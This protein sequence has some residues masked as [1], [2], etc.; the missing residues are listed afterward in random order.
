MDMDFREFDGEL[1]PDKLDEMET[2]QLA[3]RL[4]SNYIK[5][6][7]IW[8]KILWA[9][10]TRYFLVILCVATYIV[11]LRFQPTRMILIGLYIFF[12]IFWSF[13]PYAFK[14]VLI[15]KITS[16]S[17]CVHT[18]IYAVIGLIC[19]I[20]ALGMYNTAE[21]ERA[22]ALSKQKFEEVR[23]MQRSKSKKK[24]DVTADDLDDMFRP[25]DDDE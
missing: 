9:I 16:I 11:M 6:L 13:F 23:Q 12:A 18:I 15:Y 4:F 10:I 22:K 25:K 19:W 5:D 24:K 1:T 20:I 2:S 8:I 17:Y 7:G 14:C 3:I 21:Y